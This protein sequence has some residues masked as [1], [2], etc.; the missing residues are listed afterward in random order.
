MA[1]L[2]R[3]VGSVFP[4]W[5]VGGSRGRRGIR[6]HRRRRRLGCPGR[7]PGGTSGTG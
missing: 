6:F 7:L 1:P 2:V 3:F 5:G 4:A